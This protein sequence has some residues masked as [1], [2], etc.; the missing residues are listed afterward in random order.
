M[1]R[2]FRRKG[3]AEMGDGGLGCIVRSLGLRIVHNNSGHGGDVHNAARSL[4]DHGS[5]DCLATEEDTIQVDVYDPLPLFLHNCFRS[6]LTDDASIVHNEVHS[7]EGL[8]CLFDHVKDILFAGNVGFDEKCFSTKAFHLPSRSGSCLS[9][10]FRDYYVGARFGIGKTETPSQTSPAPSHDAYPVFER[11]FLENHARSLQ[12]SGDLKDEDTV[13]GLFACLSACEP[14][15]HS[16]CRF[17][18]PR[19]LYQV[20]DTPG[21][22]SLCQETDPQPGG[23]IPGRAASIITGR[24]PTAHVGFVLVF[25]ADGQSVQLHFS[26]LCEVKYVF[27]TIVQEARA[28]YWFEMTNADVSSYVGIVSHIIFGY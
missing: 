9:I 24:F 14:R 19:N 17:R 7:A 21:L 8:K 15:R 2:P 3:L 25:Y 11:E 18:I 23:W 26:V 12:F 16:R 13:N 20:R 1:L 10:Q 6:P 5:S 4:F 27:V 28:V 22:Y